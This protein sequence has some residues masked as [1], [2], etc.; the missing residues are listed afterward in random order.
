MKIKKQEDGSFRIEYEDGTIYY[1]QKG[2][3]P[4]DALIDIGLTQLKT[5]EIIADPKSAQDYFK[6]EAFFFAL[7][8]YYLKQARQN[9]LADD[10]YQRSVLEYNHEIWLNMRKRLGESGLSRKFAKRNDNK[11]GKYEI[12]YLDQLPEF[13][14]YYTHYVAVDEVEENS[15]QYNTAFNLLRLVYCKVDIRK[16]EERISELKGYCEF[17]KKTTPDE[18]NAYCTMADKF[19]CPHEMDIDLFYEILNSKTYRDIEIL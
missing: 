1:S 6:P 8:R 12:C 3:D 19:D 9:P 5:S 18:F 4:I 16:I 15:H 2:K 13:V 10:W 14:E 17:L 11:V 7:G